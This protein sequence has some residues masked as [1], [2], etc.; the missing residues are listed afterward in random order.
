MREALAF[1]RAGWLTATSYRVNALL[2]L[3]SFLLSIIPIY[4]IAGALE[5]VLANAIAGEASQYFGF[6]VL[7]LVTHGFLVLAMTSLPTAITR[8]I[9]NGSLESYL[10]TPVRL[11]SL[12]F[13]LAS[14]DLVWTVARAILFFA[15]AVVLGM[16]FTPDGV[17]A[18]LLIFAVL[19]TAHVPI[20]LLSVAAVLVFR[21]PTPIARLVL[22][23]SA[24]LGGMYYPTKVVPSW[25]QYVSGALPM[26]YGLRAFRGT[27]NGAS[28]TDVGGD[29]VVL[30]LFALVLMPI[31]VIGLRVSLKHARAT[32]SLAY[33]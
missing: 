14:N 29:L 7:G 10:A 33:H 19:V 8:S 22:T 6:V 1:L 3:F 16:R 11:P 17:P 15:A 12:L 2:S 32:G 18:A 31:G 23:A 28:F 5:P 27:L 13:G 4:F 25:L 20:G 26:T 9:S 24:F 30:S 21:N